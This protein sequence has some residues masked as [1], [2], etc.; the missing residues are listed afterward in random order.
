M[1]LVLAVD[2]DPDILE[3]I[4]AMLR[5]AGHGVVLCRP[6]AALRARLAAADYDL[7]ITDLNMSEMPGAAIAEAVARHR[8]GTPVVAMTGDSGK[9]AR[10][11]FASVL[12]KPFRREQLLRLVADLLAQRS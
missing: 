7:V 6:D 11:R 12:P 9:E 5:A 1:A 2:D 4:G 3:L 10:D 8:P